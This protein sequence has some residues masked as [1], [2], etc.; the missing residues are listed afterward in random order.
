MFVWIKVVQFLYTL[1]NLGWAKYID[2]NDHQLQT[3][4]D[5]CYVFIGNHVFDGIVMLVENFICNQQ[6]LYPF[7]MAFWIKRKPG[8]RVTSVDDSSRGYIGSTSEKTTSK[9]HNESTALERK[10]GDA[11]SENPSLK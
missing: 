11:L 7:F 6:W 8:I 3:H 2:F 1:T 9:Y 10:K 5:I 4:Q